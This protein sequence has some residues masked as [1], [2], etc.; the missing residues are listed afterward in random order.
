MGRNEAGSGDE[1]ARR[2]SYVAKAAEKQRRGQRRQWHR[3]KMSVRQP[4]PKSVGCSKAPA[5]VVQLNYIKIHEPNQKPSSAEE[6]P[7]TRMT[8]PSGRGRRGRV[9]SFHVA[10]PTRG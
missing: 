9:A 8:R 1:A 5:D 6:S 3:W 10:F 2:T 7:W 4:Q